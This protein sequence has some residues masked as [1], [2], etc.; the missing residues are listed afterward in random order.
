MQSERLF[1]GVQKFY[2]CL[3]GHLKVTSQIQMHYVLK[4]VPL[5]GQ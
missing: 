3:N 4:T 2:V 5:E 1:V